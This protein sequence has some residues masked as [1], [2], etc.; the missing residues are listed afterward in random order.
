MKP[1]KENTLYLPIMQVWFDAILS[2]EK[3]EEYREVKDTTAGRFL[4]PDKRTRY[5]LNPLVTTPAGVYSIDDYNSGNFP[6]E[7]KN[8]KYIYLAVGYHKN[9][10]TCLIELTGISFEADMVNRK[11]KC[12]W[13]ATFHLGKIVELNLKKLL[14]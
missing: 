11:G 7:P 14:K 1:T 13:V 12:F 4:L 5:K 8:F 3:T 10:D 9:R 6:F 2:G